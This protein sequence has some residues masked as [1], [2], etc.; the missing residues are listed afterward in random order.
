MLARL[1][2]PGSPVPAFAFFLV[3]VCLVCLVKVKVL[4]S[5][6]RSPVPAFALFLVLIAH[7]VDVTLPALQMAGE[8]VFI[9]ANPLEISTFWAF[10]WCICCQILPFQLDFSETAPPNLLSCCPGLSPSYL[11]DSYH[12]GQ[13]I[14]SF[15]SY[16]G[17]PWSNIASLIIP[18]DPI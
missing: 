9:F 6:P 2:N 12:L 14:G 16:H 3:L 13:T 11:V 4:P 7:K 17:I 10:T 1:C 8:S 18:R 15:W 5:N